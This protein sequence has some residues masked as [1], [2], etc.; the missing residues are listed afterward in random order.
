MGMAALLLVGAR[1]LLP[2]M[3]I[4]IPGGPDEGEVLS[5]I[6]PDP[7]FLPGKGRLWRE[8]PVCSERTRSKSR[9]FEKADS[10]TVLIITPGNPT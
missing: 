9:S 5:A 3:G 4:D 6:T 1:E 7:S 2:R 10:G 8:A